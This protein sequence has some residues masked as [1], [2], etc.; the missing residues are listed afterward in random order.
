M[1]FLENMTKCVQGWDGTEFKHNVV[2]HPLYI[3]TTMYNDFETLLVST[4]TPHILHVQI[5]RPSKLNAMNDK[6][7]AEFREFFDRVGEDV[8]AR[9]IVVSGSGGSRNSTAVLSAVY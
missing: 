9:A 1:S 2:R 7:W 3:I 4:P 8:H 5:N 6:F